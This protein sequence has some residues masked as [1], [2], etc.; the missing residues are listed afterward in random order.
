MGPTAG[1][2]EAPQPRAYPL[3]IK[4]QQLLCDFGSVESQTQAMDVELWDDVL[5][6][7]LQGQAPPCPMLGGRRSG[8]LKNGA[9]KRDELLKR[10]KGWSGVSGGL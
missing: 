10:E 4:L 5:Q 2:G 9:P 6:C 3:L 1:A 8:I 7:I